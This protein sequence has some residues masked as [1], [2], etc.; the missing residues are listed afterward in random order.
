[1][2]NLNRSQ[3]VD[4]PLT[5]TL[6]WTLRTERVWITEGESTIVEGSG[7]SGLSIVRLPLSRTIENPMAS[8]VPGCY[9]ANFS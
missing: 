6:F 4:P 9:V 3:W 1:M 8:F 7:T 5:S 2:F